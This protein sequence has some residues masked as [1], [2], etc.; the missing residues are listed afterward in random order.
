M[1]IEGGYVVTSAHLVLPYA[2]VNVTLA[3][4]QMIP[5]APV[6]HVDYLSNTDASTRLMRSDDDG[7]HGLLN[8]DAS[9]I[10]K[11]SVTVRHAIPVADARHTR[12]A[13][14][15]LKVTRDSTTEDETQADSLGQA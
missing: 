4:G 2:H 3:D 12:S 5:D 15:L 6:L 7:G 9:L 11:A 10:Y 14:Y 13:G 1:L 8:L